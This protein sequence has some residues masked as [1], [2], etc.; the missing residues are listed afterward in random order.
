MTGRS[1]LHVYHIL[2]TFYIQLNA[3]YVDYLVKS[4]LKDDICT[5]DVFHE[6]QDVNGCRTK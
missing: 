2:N 6:T 4:R 3:Q 1:D 5:A